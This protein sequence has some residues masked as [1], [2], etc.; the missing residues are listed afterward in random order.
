MKI[1]AITVIIYTL[2][3]CL[4]ANAQDKQSGEVEL[5]AGYGHTAPYQASMKL[6]IEGKKLNFS[7]FIGIKGITPYSS[8]H[9]GDESYTFTGTEPLSESIG[10]QY[11]SNKETES[12]GIISEYGFKLD[13]SPSKCHILFV[14]FEG[15]NVSQNETGT[16]NERLLTAGSQTTSNKWRINS[17][18]LMENALSAGAGYRF[19]YSANGS[20]ELKYHFKNENEAEEK[21]LEAIELQGFEDFSKSLLKADVKIFHHNLHLV[22][23]H[24]FSKVDLNVAARYENRLIRSNDLQWLDEKL[25]MEDHFRH[26]YWTGAVKASV[27]YLPVK[28]LR[29]FAELEYAYTQMQGRSLNDFLPKVVIEWRPWSAG[30]LSLRYDRLLVRPDFKYLNP[31]EIREPFALRQ[32]NENLVGIHINKASFDF[33]CKLPVVAIHLNCG[34]IY[35]DDGFNGIWMERGN[36]RIYQWGNEGIRHA[37]NI[38]PSIRIK[39][40]DKTEINAHATVLWDNRIAAAINMSNSNWGYAAHLDLKQGLPAKFAIIVY[41]DYSFGNTLDLYRRAGTAYTF[42][43]S[44]E[45]S[46]GKHLHAAL[47]G[48]YHRYADE[49]ITQGAYTGLSYLH[50]EHRYHAGISVR[51]KW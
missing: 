12:M 39:A 44:L 5:G 6:N 19:S 15:E 38:S 30:L 23:N 16:F 1:K 40:A 34:Y 35:S 17:P 22:L 42:G 9:I 49:L 45:R 32:G 4:C 47:E 27:N 13:Y 36:R 11:F 26:E 46:F 51:Y 25:T 20:L 43:A 21:Q 48:G 50:P 41:G 29:L 37:L 10:N 18:M 28:S 7:P 14:D 33:D 8:K 2:A 24:H 31:A 3:T